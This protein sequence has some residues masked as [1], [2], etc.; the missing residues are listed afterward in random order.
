M[1]VLVVCYVLFVG[2]VV[3]CLL[4]VVL[5]VFFWFRCGSSL[6]V[7]VRRA[8]G[9]VCCSATSLCASVLV[10]VCLLFC[11]WCDVLV[12]VVCW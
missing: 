2:V 10:D 6:F 7:V 3:C 4:P 11:L 8:L 12:F 1:F 5:G 9:V